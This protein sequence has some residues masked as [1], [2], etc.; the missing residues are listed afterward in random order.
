MIKF[1]R[2]EK[3][4]KIKA[5]IICVDNGKKTQVSEV[6]SHNVAQTLRR[7]LLQQEENCNMFGVPVVQFRL[8][9]V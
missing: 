2:I 5:V 1:K 9:R 7:E 8:R 4:A 3:A 6:L